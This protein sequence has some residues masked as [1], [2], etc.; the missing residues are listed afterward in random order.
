MGNT[1][2]IQ[3]WQQYGENLK[4][5]HLF[6][7]VFVLA[8]I[9]F[10]LF[11]WKDAACCCCGGS[12]TGCVFL[13]L[14][15]ILYLAFF[16]FAAVICVMGYMVRTQAD[17]IPING[18]FAKDVSLKE[19]LDHVQTNYPAF[20]TTVFADLVDGLELLIQPV[21]SLYWSAL[22]FSS[23]ACPYACA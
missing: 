3:A 21:S 10:S 20:W 18:V 17:K 15:S 4:Y 16:G 1:E 22:S 19:I 2:E 8:I 6:P 5:M 7:Y 23:T 14:F 12:V 11:W 9:F 13:M